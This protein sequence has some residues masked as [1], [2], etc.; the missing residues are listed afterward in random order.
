MEHPRSRLI[1]LVAPLFALYV[2]WGSTYLAIR[3]A[4]ETMPP[5]LMAAVRFALAGALMYVF[6]IRRGDPDGS[7]R[8]GRRQ[9]MAALIV[10]GLLLAGGNGL[11]SWGEQFISSGLAALLVATVPLWMVVLSHFFGDEKLTWP[12]VV[13][14]VIGLIGVAVLARPS[15]AGNGIVGVA[16]VLTAAILW[17]SGSIYARRAPLPRRPLVATSLEMLCGSAVLAVAAV[18][19]G[20]L[21]QVHLAALST[22]S[23][24]ALAYLVF[25]G[26][27]VAFTSY[28]WLLK[29]SR[30]SILGT[31]AYVNPAVAVVLGFLV[32]GEPL[33]LPTI[34][35]GGIIIVAVALIVTARSVQRPG[36]RRRAAAAAAAEVSAEPPAESGV[37]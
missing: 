33:T 11:V 35:G 15:G 8:P 19:S 6:A 32:L 21:G 24:L 22:R 13:G 1:T 30:P 3:I 20:E 27:I 37:A 12:V 7:D 23:I 28:V 4:I 14:V 34:I 31:Y 2:I 29:T 18:A 25:F 5:F 36:E 26:S 17:A 16:A 9:W 10:G